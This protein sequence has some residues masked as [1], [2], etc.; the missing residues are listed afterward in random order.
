M[1]WLALSID[2]HWSQVRGAQPLRRRTAIA[3]RLLGGL[4]LLAGLLICLRADHASMAALVWSMSAVAS[5]LIVAFTL[6]WR[7]RCFAV[8]VAWVPAP[9]SGT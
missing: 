9:R 5:A 2:S 6:A 7:P 4:A 8:L 3:L 1:A